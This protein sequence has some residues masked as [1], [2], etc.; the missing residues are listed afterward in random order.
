MIHTFKKI[1][2][3][4][5]LIVAISCDKDDA[6]SDPEVIDPETENPVLDSFS[7][8]FG[9]EISR[10]F[11]GTILDS[12]Q[13]PISNVEI[14]VGN[15]STTTD[16]NGIFIINDA[17]VNERF[18]YIKAS[19]N[20][21]IHASRSVT[22]TS[23]VNKVTIMMLEELVAG[24]TSSGVSE[25]ISLSNGAS[26]SLN[27]AYI[28]EDGS[29]YEGSVAVILHH[30]DPV[31]ENIN[32][33]MPGMLYAA[34]SENEE[35]LLQ[36]LGMLA[37]ELRGSNGEDLNLADGTT[38]EIRVPVDASLLSTAPNTIPLWYFDEDRGYWIEDGEATL[39][40]SEYVGTV[41]H[42]SFWNCDI[43]A[44]AIILC[45]NL[46]D[47]LSNSLSNTIVIIT[48]QTYGSRAGF[49][50]AE[51]IVCGLIPSNEP[52]VLS[53]HSICN[54]NTIVYSENIGPFTS[55]STIDITVLY[56]NEST[57]T[58]TGTFTNCNGDLI[59]NGYVT[60]T[61]NDEEYVD[62]VTDGTYEISFIRCI[63]DTTFVI[64]AI[65]YDTV[66]SSGEINYTLTSPLTNL[67]AISSCNDATEFITYQIDDHAPITHINNI[68]Y[69]INGPQI[70]VSA[71]SSVGT[72]FFTISNITISDSALLQIELEDINGDTI[73]Q[74]DTLNILLNLTALGNVGEYIDANFSGTYIDSNNVTHTIDGAVHM[75]R[76]F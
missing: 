23:G 49:T 15:S 71:S 45:V 64:E 22:P 51:G 27:G 46:S 58:V 28:K 31:N 50:N 34:N 52:L 69:D 65:D 17:I 25:T 9:A 75:I 24:T 6:T 20:G 40:G 29:S 33:Q 54:G 42:F 38:A 60:L 14:T 72:I 61:Y 21:Y 18:A 26:V 63:D 36:T 10:S 47:E 41:T 30:L 19:K 55:D 8:N 68:N 39:I 76:D 11:I 66:Q 53:V 48:S 5:V 1:A 43:P 2:L 70:F 13:Q 32:L 56:Q 73:G 37:V 4:L 57:E 7:D 12:N 67:A 16:S 3:F 62:I 44:E 35:R 59:T 74:N